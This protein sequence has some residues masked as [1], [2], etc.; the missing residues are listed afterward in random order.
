MVG[1]ANEFARVGLQAIDGMLVS[2][3]SGTQWRNVGVPDDIG[4]SDLQEIPERLMSMV[5]HALEARLWSAAWN[6]C[7]MPEILPALLPPDSTQ[8]DEHKHVH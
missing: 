7:A 4:V 6:E 3:F 5:L 8:R 1:N 2:D